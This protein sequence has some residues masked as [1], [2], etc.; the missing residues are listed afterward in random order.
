MCEAD[1]RTWL[2]TVL[3]VWL[4]LSTARQVFDLIGKL[5]IPVAFN[6]FQ[7]LSCITGLFAVCQYRICLLIVLTISSVVSAVYNTLLILW[8]NGV[9]GDTTRPILSAGLPYSYR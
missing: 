2:I 1:S 5:W 6:L 8:Y 3:S 9:F 7:M 4:V